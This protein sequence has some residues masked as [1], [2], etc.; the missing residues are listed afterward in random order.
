MSNWMTKYRKPMSTVYRSEEGCEI[1]TMVGL[2]NLSVG[3]M[4]IEMSMRAFTAFFDSRFLFCFQFCRPVG[5]NKVTV[6]WLKASTLN[7]NYMWAG[8]LVIFL[9]IFG[10][11]MCNKVCQKVG[12]QSI[13]TV[14][15]SFFCIFLGLIFLRLLYFFNTFVFNTSIFY[16]ICKEYHLFSFLHSVSVFPCYIFPHKFSDSSLSLEERK[17][18]IKKPN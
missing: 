6:R 11:F 18:I 4:M 15:L 14:R 2:L 17:E 5:L 12:T 7:L 8:S 3:R 9:G 16:H 10:G 1:L 13:E